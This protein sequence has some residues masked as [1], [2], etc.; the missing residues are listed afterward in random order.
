[1]AHGFLLLRLTYLR[2]FEN[3]IHDMVDEE[4]RLLQLIDGICEHSCQLVEQWVSRD[5][6]VVEF[7]E[8]LGTQTSSIINPEMLDRFVIPVYHR[9]MAPCLE[10]GKHVAF[11]SDGYILGIVDRLLQTGV[12]ASIRRISA[13]ESTA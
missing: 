11:H 10:K 7:P 13:T 9:L 8:D 12:A 5:V 6:D 2:G 1:M 4:P 3:V